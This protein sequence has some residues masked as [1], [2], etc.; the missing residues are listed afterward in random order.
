MGALGVDQFLNFNLGGSPGL[1]VAC[2]R[3]VDVES[4]Y[5]NDIS[6]VDERRRSSCK[7]HILCSDKYL[8]E[9]SVPPLVVLVG[10]CRG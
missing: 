4:A 5:F 10:V 3:A 2:P 6:E 1:D 9:F 7:L 8:L